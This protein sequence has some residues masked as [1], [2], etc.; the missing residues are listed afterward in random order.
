MY[1][2]PSVSVFREL[3][4]TKFKSKLGLDIVFSEICCFVDKSYLRS[5]KDVKS[6]IGNHYEADV[7]DVYRLKAQK[8]V[9]RWV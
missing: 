6:M 4:C 5:V 3:S 8:F 7:K 1:T 2:E 9:L